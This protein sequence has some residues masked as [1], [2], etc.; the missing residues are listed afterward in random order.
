MNNTVAHPCGYRLGQ[1]F[2][3]TV[4]RRFRQKAVGH[5]DGEVSMTLFHCFFR[6]Q[7]NHV[8][9]MMMV[10]IRMM[11]TLTRLISPPTSTFGV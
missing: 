5:R 1:T 6:P 11:M 7:M 3:D 10:N 8:S 9:P 4:T 2:G